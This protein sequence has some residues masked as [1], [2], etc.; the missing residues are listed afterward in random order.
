VGEYMNE[1]DIQNFLDQGSIVETKMVIY[2][3]ADKDNS[4]TITG[5]DS[6][7]S[8]EHNETR[9]LEKYGIIGR[10]VAR[11]LTCELQNITDDFS[12]QDKYI[13]L[14]IGSKQVSRGLQLYDFENV[15][16]ITKGITVDN[17]GWITIDY[18][19]TN[20]TSTKYFN[21]YT[22]NLDLKPNTNYA[23]VTEIKDVFGTGSVLPISLLPNNNPVQFSRGIDYRFA[24]LL[25]NETHIE[26]RST[27][28]TFATA[29]LGLRTFIAFGVGQKGSI[30]F[31]LSVRENT[32][33]TP[34]Q[35]VYDPYP[36]D[37]TFYSMGTFIVEKPDDD[38][39]VDATKFTASDFTTLFNAEFDSSYTDEQYEDSFDELLENGE[40]ITALWLAQYTC[41]QVGVELATTDF[42]NNSFIITSNQFTNGDSCRD[43]MKAIGMLA[44]SWVRIGWDNKCYIDFSVKNSVTNNYDVIDNDN[45]YSL[46]TQNKQYG[47]INKVTVGLSNVEGESFSVQDSADILE[48]GV[49]ELRIMDNPLLYTSELR[50]LGIAGGERLFGLKYVPFEAE[51]IGHV[52]LSGDELIKLVNMENEEYLTYP[53][54][55]IISYSGYIKTTL[56]ADAETDVESDYDYNGTGKLSKNVSNATLAIDRANSRITGTITSINA[57]NTNLNNNY[58]TKSEND[59]TTKA[60]QDSINHIQEVQNSF[61]LDLE[62]FKVQLNNNTDK[63]TNMGYNFQTDGL[64]ILTNTDKNNATLDNNGLQVRNYDTL[65]AIYNNN[66][67]GVAKLIVTGDSQI[68]YMKTMKRTITRNGKSEKVTSEFYLRDLIEDL[69]DLENN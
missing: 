16:E 62:G 6:V 33:L 54:N 38:E 25:P 29:D 57:I 1:R 66:G 59:A 18:D 51:T 68:G 4:I 31:R 41:K 23:I 40:P 28:E 58:Y 63:I 60:N 12:V 26:T 67:S 56:S 11:E 64:H 8:W 13:D 20:G 34:E 22:H 9:Y 10:F 32:N 24:D 3:K 46:V 61:S 45:Y 55:R 19:N 65:L 42:T 15:R 43:V 52:W 7:K 48:H 17:N 53:L 47:A 44:F 30:T 36:K 35:F 14:Y 2:D 5:Y 39:V 21:Y 49:H 37:T 69:E 27:I 50:S